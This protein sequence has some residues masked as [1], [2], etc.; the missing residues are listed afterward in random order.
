LVLQH[1]SPLPTHRRTQTRIFSSC[2]PAYTANNGTKLTP[3]IRLTQSAP[4]RRFPADFGVVPLVGLGVDGV[5]VVELPLVAFPV[6][7]PAV[8]FVPLLAAGA[9]A[10]SGVEVCSDCWPA[11]AF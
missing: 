9:G 7:L 8:A 1:R 10:P 5:V 6:V 4:T 11:Q 2:A 3:T